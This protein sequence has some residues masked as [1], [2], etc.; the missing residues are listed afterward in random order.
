MEKTKKGNLR[1]SLL[2][3]LLQVIITIMFNYI[4]NSNIKTNIQNIYYIIPGESTSKLSNLTHVLHNLIYMLTYIKNAISKMVQHHNANYKY[5][6][7]DG[8]DYTTVPLREY[9]LRG[10]L[11]NSP[12]IGE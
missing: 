1:K 11:V 3:K 10:N 6:C 7:V 12:D 9:S 2:H 4:V 8:K 5:K